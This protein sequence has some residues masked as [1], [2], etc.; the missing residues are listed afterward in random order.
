[1]NSPSFPLC[2]Q[3]RPKR[4]TLIYQWIMSNLADQGPLYSH[5]VSD[6]LSLTNEEVMVCA[7]M[8]NSVFPGCLQ[9]NRTIVDGPLLTTELGWKAI[10][11]FIC[12]HERNCHGVLLDNFYQLLSREFFIVALASR[13]VKLQQIDAQL[14][15]MPGQKKLQFYF[16]LTCLVNLLLGS[17]ITD[18]SKKILYSHGLA[19]SKSKISAYYIEKGLKFPEDRNEVSRIWLWMMQNCQG[20]QPPKPVSCQASTNCSSTSLHTISALLPNSL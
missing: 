12:N 9:L 16:A 4:K 3:N 1:M 20:T 2:N 8:I 7:E 15:V 19:T 17:Y 13:W 11:T 14:Y 6:V 10:L 5:K 18:C